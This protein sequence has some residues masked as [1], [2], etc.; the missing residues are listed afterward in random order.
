[1][2]KLAMTCYT[3]DA[4]LGPSWFDSAVPNGALVFAMTTRSMMTVLRLRWGR[5]SSVIFR[6]R[7]VAAVIIVSTTY[8]EIVR[9][10]DIE[11]WRERERG[12]DREG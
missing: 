5:G 7:R 8:S 3:E 12:S 1:M 11:R 6:W 10:R 2:N 9:D 4:N